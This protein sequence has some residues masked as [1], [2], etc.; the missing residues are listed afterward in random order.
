MNFPD[1]LKYTKD[2]EWTSGTGQNEVKIG[3]TDYAQQELGDIVFVDLPEK[4]TE[5]VQG[6]TFGSIESVKAVSDLYSPVNGKIIAIN[7]RVGDEPELVNSD[8]YGDGWL[9]T[10][11]IE[12]SGQLDSL[13][14]SSS[15]TSYVEEE[16]KD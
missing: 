15:Y 16:N 8:P 13:M 14:D 5:V 4:G 7:D 2:H 12:D 10:V 1:E 6:E 3:I 9:V 11:E